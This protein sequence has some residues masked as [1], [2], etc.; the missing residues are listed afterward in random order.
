MG[1]NKNKPQRKKRAEKRYWRVTIPTKKHLKKFIQYYNGE[2]PL[3][4]NSTQFKAFALS[5]LSFNTIR[6]KAYKPKNLSEMGHN[7]TLTMLVSNRTFTHIGHTITFEKAMYINR[8]MAYEFSVTLSLMISNLHSVKKMPLQEALEKFCEVYGL[9]IDEDI[10]MD[11]LLKI[12]RRRL[13]KI[14]PHCVH[15][16][17]TENL[18]LP[19]PASN[20]LFPGLKVNQLSL[21]F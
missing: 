8:M 13:D 15:K 4:D 10:T 12:W 11:N 20:N 16:N 7:D 2:Q 18:I 17:V 19:F 9:E 1:K 5:M 6:D 14:E 3:L 21:D